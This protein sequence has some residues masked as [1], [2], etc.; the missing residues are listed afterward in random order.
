MRNRE[1]QLEQTQKELKQTQEQLEEVTR[2]R[3][4][5]KQQVETL[6]ADRQQVQAQLEKERADRQQLEA[7]AQ[8]KTQTKEGRSVTPS[9][10]L[11]SGRRLA[12]PVESQ[13]P[14]VKTYLRRG[15][16]DS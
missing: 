16:G 8:L 1:R 10:D 3:D 13:A 5:L 2:D 6:T 7:D 12:E 15:G 11:P 4:E 14:K 9:K